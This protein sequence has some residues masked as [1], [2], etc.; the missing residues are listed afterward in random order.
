MNNIQ[1]YN[2]CKPV[3]NKDSTNNEHHGIVQNFNIIHL[4]S[5]EIINEIKSFNNNICLRDH[6]NHDHYK[7]YTYEQLFANVDSLTQNVIKNKYDN[8]NRQIDVDE[9]FSN[10]VT[11]QYDGN[12]Y[13]IKSL[14]P[15]FVNNC[16]KSLRA[17][18]RIST[19][20]MD[21]DNI[22]QNKYNASSVKPLIDNYIKYIENIEK[23]FIKDILNKSFDNIESHRLYC[24][25]KLTEIL[26]S[27]I[28]KIINSDF[29]Q[30][31]VHV[32]N[33]IMPDVYTIIINRF[34]ITGNPIT[35]TNGQHYMFNS[36]PVRDTD[37]LN[38]LINTS[39]EMAYQTCNQE[40]KTL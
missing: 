31:Q 39:Y 24:N 6:L 18:F 40:I 1:Q 35:C 38:I 33:S 23:N 20:T 25:R 21:C 19:S 2:Y 22:R 10:P 15:Q 11:M 36:H 8:Y 37:G 34:K 5:N 7:D 13:T 14:P 16:P 12:T 4:S 28:E 9:F 30:N 27:G 32:T 3:S 29:H 26:S 17:H